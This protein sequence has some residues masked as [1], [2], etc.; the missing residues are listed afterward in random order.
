[1]HNGTTNTKVQKGA[2][3][4]YWQP[5]KVVYNG[6]RYYVKPRFGVGPYQVLKLTKTMKQSRSNNKRWSRTVDNTQDGSSKF[7]LEIPGS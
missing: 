2:G 6:L 4:T 3:I 1:M 5:P 7:K